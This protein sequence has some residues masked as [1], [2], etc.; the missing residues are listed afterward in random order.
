MKSMEVMVVRIYIT[1][2]EKRLK[3]ILG[4]LHDQVKVK[5]V[6]VFRG[7]TGFG[8]T[9]AMHSTSLLD[10]S[11]NLPLVVEFFDFAEHVLT[12]LGHLESMVPPEHIITWTAS[13]YV[14]A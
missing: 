1:E 2:G 3:S 5:G 14:K 13:T 11:L 7:I 12:A 6:T 8:S 4:Y 10:L 9:G